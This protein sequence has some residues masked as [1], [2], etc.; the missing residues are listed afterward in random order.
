MEFFN[1]KMTTNKINAVKNV[2][3]HWKFDC[4]KDFFD[5]VSIVIDNGYNTSYIDSVIIALFYKQSHADDLLIVMPETLKYSYLQDLLFLFI[6]FIRLGAS[7]SSELVNEVRNYSVLCGW[8][9]KQDITAKY[10]AIDFLDFVLSGLSFRGIKC[11]IID[12]KENAIVQT[13]QQN[14]IQYN[15]VCDITVKSITES[16]PTSQFKFCEIPIIIPIYLNRRKNNCKI[17]IQKRICF[18]HNSDPVQS[19]ASWVIYSIICKNRDNSFYTIVKMQEQWY[20][21]TNTKIPSIS[22]I[23]LKESN[24]VEK[25]KQEC[26]VIIYKLDGNFSGL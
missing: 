11:D 25:I 3:K 16:W 24:V 1:S 15:V 9:E 5:D 19:N 8:K 26:S 21:S 2:K 7:I 22:K 4:E 17:D 12:E 10:E 18:K 6:D 23:S 14:F 20:L 13:N